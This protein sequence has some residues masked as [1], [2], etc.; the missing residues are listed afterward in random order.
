MQFFCS[1]ARHVFV[2][3]HTSIRSRNDVQEEVEP[4]KEDKLFGCRYCGL[5]FSSGKQLGGHMRHHTLVL[6]KNPDAYNSIHVDPDGVDIDGIDFELNEEDQL[7]CDTCDEVF[8]SKEELSEHVRNHTLDPLVSLEMSQ[9]DTLSSTQASNGG[10]M[11]CHICDRL[12]SSHKS[13]STHMYKKHRWVN[14]KSAFDLHKKM[15]TST[16][17]SQN[18]S[19]VATSSRKRSLSPDNVFDVESEFIDDP[20]SVPTTSAKRIRRPQE[21]ERRNGAPSNSRLAFGLRN[22]GEI[23]VKNHPNLA[24]Q[25]HEKSYGCMY[26]EK[27]F[28]EKSELLEHVRT[29]REAATITDEDLESQ[30]NAHNRERFVVQTREGAE[31]HF[32]FEQYDSTDGYRC[33]ECDESFRDKLQMLIHMA[34]HMDSKLPNSDFKSLLV[35]ADCGLLAPYKC[36]FCGQR[37]INKKYRNLHLCKHHRNDILQCEICQKLFICKETLKQHYEQHAQD[38]RYQCEFCGKCFRSKVVLKRHSQNQCDNNENS[39]AET[40]TDHA[41]EG[42]AE[43]IIDQHFIKE[44]PLE[45]RTNSFL[46]LKIL[47]QTGEQFNLVF[48]YHQKISRCGKKY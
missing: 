31:E 43:V 5:K 27:R 18:Q 9:N 26:C 24:A 34:Y 48:F 35:K 37:F 44:E 4:P 23:Y 30:V 15:S 12:F 33:S 45:V 11:M 46:C 40:E 7:I 20:I 47:F 22:N 38:K 21:F 25:F 16:A 3:T 39:T 42:D 14:R 8:E 19:V 10:F 29:H 17:V 1:I 2:H 13:L 41:N 28:S 36:N 32:I 6:Q